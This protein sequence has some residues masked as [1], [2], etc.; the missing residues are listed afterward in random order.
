MYNKFNVPFDIQCEL[1]IFLYDSSQ[2]IFNS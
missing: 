2:F 1:P